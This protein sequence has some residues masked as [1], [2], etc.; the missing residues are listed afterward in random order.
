MKFNFLKMQK[1]G[2]APLKK[3]SRKCCAVA[4]YRLTKNMSGVGKRLL[5][6]LQARK[7]DGWKTCVTLFCYKILCD[8]LL[9]QRNI[10]KWPNEMLTVLKVFADVSAITQ[11]REREIHKKD[12]ENKKECSIYKTIINTNY[13]LI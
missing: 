5:I 8:P 12:N 13:L 6:M 7:V 9:W 11:K 10:I 3:Y 1:D 2:D 4:E